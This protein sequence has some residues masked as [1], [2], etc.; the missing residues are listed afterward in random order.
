MYKIYFENR[1]ISINSD[2]DAKSINENEVFISYKS[3]KSFYKA[4][5]E[6]RKDT[7]I[8]CLHVQTNKPKKVL[9]K[10]KNLFKPITA[11]GGLVFNNEAKLLLIKRSGIWDIP[12]GKVEKGEKNRD[13]AIREVEEECGI[14]GLK[15]VEKA[16][17]SYHSYVYRG[18]EILKTTYWYFMEY[19]GNEKL[20]P[21]TEEDI[22]EVAWKSLDEVEGI[23]PYTHKSLVDILELVLVTNQS[24]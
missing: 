13:A 15:I 4:V 1:F 21:Q 8:V 6:F 3:K 17:K 16:G 5:K 7:N 10:L 22:T 14:S 18:K 12:K 23:L 9:K 11:A 24:N 2:V 20:V 19:L